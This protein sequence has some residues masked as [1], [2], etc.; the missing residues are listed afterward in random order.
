MQHGM[1]DN[2]KQLKI[3]PLVLVC[4]ILEP[5]KCKMEVMIQAMNHW[6]TIDAEWKK[7][8]KG[9][10][11]PKDPTRSGKDKGTNEI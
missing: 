4:S 8:W 1:N 2:I 11:M 9:M 7:Y 10:V 6:N 5:V 3:I